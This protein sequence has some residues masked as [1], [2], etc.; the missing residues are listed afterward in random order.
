MVI[1]NQHGIWMNNHHYYWMIWIM[2][3]NANICNES[4]QAH[5]NIITTSNKW[6]ILV[7][8]RKQIVSTWSTP[9]VRYTA[10]GL[11]FVDNYLYFGVFG[12]WKF[13]FR[14]PIY[15]KLHMKAIGNITILLLFCDVVV[16]VYILYSVYY[17]D[18][19]QVLY[20]VNYGRLG[21]K[22]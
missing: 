21:W 19:Y 16:V 17:C 11:Q 4:K 6:P 3:T 9:R 20:M 10:F 7:H 15:H 13:K 14:I 12:K 22:I 2:D 5:N 8:Q 1:N 18:P